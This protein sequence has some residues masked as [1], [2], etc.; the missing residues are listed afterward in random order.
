MPLARLETIETPTPNVEESNLEQMEP[1]AKDKDP[2]I[3][4]IRA[5]HQK[6]IGAL[7]GTTFRSGDAG[8]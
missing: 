8:G 3:A 6:H 5:G 2:E 1:A 4:R 7:A